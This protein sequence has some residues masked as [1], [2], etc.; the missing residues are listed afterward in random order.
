[1]VAAETGQVERAGPQQF[2]AGRRDRARLRYRTARLQ[3]QIAGGG[4]T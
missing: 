2:Q 1:M 3:C 4:N